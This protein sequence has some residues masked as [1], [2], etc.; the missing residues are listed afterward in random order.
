[1][2]SPSLDRLLNVPL[3][4]RGLTEEKSMATLGSLLVNAA[5]LT[6]PDRS[7]DER[8]ALQTA[9]KDLRS[10]V[11]ELSPGHA[12]RHS[13]GQTIP[14]DIP[15]VLAFPNGAEDPDPQSGYYAVYLFASD[16]QFVNLCL[17][18]GTS[19]V[20]SLG[21]LRARTTAIREFCPDTADLALVPNLTKQEGR[22]ADYI[23]GTV[24]AK[25]YDP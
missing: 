11:D 8:T 7:S 23:R 14:A 17:G 5:K 18:V 25:V 1:M 6:N 10:A 20:R 4:R 3:K 13:E 24:V 15:W 21:A 2:T 19:K 22:A 9:L 12:T 16:G